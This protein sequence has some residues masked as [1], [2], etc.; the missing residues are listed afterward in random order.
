MIVAM[1]KEAMLPVSNDT[2]VELQRAVAQVH[3]IGE[4]D[5]VSNNRERGWVCRL[6]CRIDR[7]RSQ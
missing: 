4:K 6:P 7:V 3:M 1:D 5:L 2:G